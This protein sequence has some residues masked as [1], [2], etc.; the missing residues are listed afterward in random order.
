MTTPQSF[1]GALAPPRP[2][3]AS[4]HRGQGG[5]GWARV[6]QGGPGWA[7][8]PLNIS[9]RCPDFVCIYCVRLGGRV[10]IYRLAPA[11]L[12]AQ[13]RHCTESALDV[14]MCTTKTVMVNL[15]LP[16]LCHARLVMNVVLNTVQCTCCRV[17]VLSDSVHGDN[18]QSFGKLQLCAQAHY[19]TPVTL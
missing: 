7:M 8:A 19:L 10:C 5:P 18:C 4:L 15:F 9:R 3:M 16:H 14:C 11:V 13:R 6:G 2:P 12:K 17:E 1:G